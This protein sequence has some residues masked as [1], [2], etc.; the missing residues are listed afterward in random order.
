[1]LVAIFGT[2]IFLWVANLLWAA[3]NYYIIENDSLKGVVLGALFVIVV[4]KMLNP[5]T[6]KV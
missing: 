1:V 2:G 5:Y 3:I 4:C 6:I